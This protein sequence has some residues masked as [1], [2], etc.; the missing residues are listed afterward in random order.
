MG[1]NVSIDRKHSSDM[2]EAAPPRA[3]T[4]PKK[5]NGAPH[6]NKNAQRIS[7]QARDLLRVLATGQA[8]SAAGAAAI[9]GMSERTA[10]DMLTKDYIQAELHKLIKQDMRTVGVLRA[11]AAYTHLLEKAESEYVRADLAKDAL[12]Q[13]GVRDKLDGARQPAAIG[14]VKITFISSAA[15]PGATAVQIDVDT[16]Q[17]SSKSEG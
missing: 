2:S 14:G 5:K 1:N 7:K 6:G 3:L 17:T 16:A 12:A 10:Q 15:Q 11:H 9:V 13:A 8:T 4:V